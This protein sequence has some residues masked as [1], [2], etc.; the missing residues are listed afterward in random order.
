MALSSK[1]LTQLRGLAQSL[2]VADVFALDRNHLMQEI[3][4]KQLEVSIPA[5]VEVPLPAYDARLMTK[6]PAKRMDIDELGKLLAPYV[7]LGLRV[8]FTPEMWKMTY[9]RKSDQGTLR[10]PPRV[11]LQC[12]RKLM[13]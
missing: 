7:E 2:G 8:E 10:M 13:E 9:N 5:R 11:V 12:A 6:P 4:R 3:Q 1:T